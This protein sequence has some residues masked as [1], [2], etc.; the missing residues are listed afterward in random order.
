MGHTRGK[1]YHPVTQG[2]IERY[3]RSMKNQVLLEND[4]LPGAPEIRIEAFVDYYHHERYH[5]SLNNQA[6]AYVQCR[7]GQAILKRRITIKQKTMTSRHKLHH[8]M[9]A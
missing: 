7:R 8:Q 6:P 1:P 3:H 2:K 9:A 5:E 4:Y